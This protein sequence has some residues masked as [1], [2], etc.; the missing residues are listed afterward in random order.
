[1]FQ[2]EEEKGFVVS[3]IFSSSFVFVPIS[4]L[5]LRPCE[6]L[7]WSLF[8]LT[9]CLIFKISSF[10]CFYLLPLFFSP[11]SLVSGSLFTQSLTGH[12]L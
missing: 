7:S 4:I 2:E 9:F 5:C 8:Q 11:V 10:G 1:M 3:V 12:K 6:C